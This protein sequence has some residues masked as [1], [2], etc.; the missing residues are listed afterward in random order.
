MSSKTVYD[1]IK[2]AHEDAKQGNL[3]AANKKLN[4]VVIAI[5]NGGDLNTIVRQNDK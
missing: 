2:E 5:E 1:L 4:A 3:D